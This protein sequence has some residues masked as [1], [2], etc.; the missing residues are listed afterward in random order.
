VLKRGNGR[1]TNSTEAVL[2]FAKSDSYYFDA[3]AVKEGFADKRAGNPGRY[4]WSHADAGL[5][6]GGPHSLHKGDGIVD[7]WNTD[8]NA[9]GRC[10]RSAWWLPLETTGSTESWF[11][12]PG[13]QEREIRGK[14][15]ACVDDKTE[16]MTK[17]GW[18]CHSELEDGD[19]IL[20][21]NKDLARLVWQPATFHRYEVKE[22]PMVSI[23]KRDLSM[24][25]TPNHRCLV[26]TQK[27]NLRVTEASALA[28]SNSIPV[29]A[30]MT[31]DTDEGCGGDF[32]ELLGWFLAEGHIKRNGCVGIS[33]SV[34]VNPEKVARIE[35]LLNRCGM[36]YVKRISKR[37]WR[38]RDASMAEFALSTGAS[39]GLLEAAPGKEMNE[40]LAMLPPHNAARL[41]AGLI[42]GDGHVR[43]D[44]RAC[45]VQK[46]KKTIDFVHLLA[47]RL[48]YRGQVGKRSDGTYT[49]FLT[50][51]RWLTLRSTDGKPM[52]PKTVN[53]S[54]VVWC[55]SVPSTFWLARRNGKQFITG[56]TFPAKLPELC[57]KMSTSE[58]GVCG[59]CGTPFAR[60]LDKSK[61]SAPTA[62]MKVAGCDSQGQYHGENQGDYREGEAQP[63]SDSKRSILESMAT[64]SRTIGWRAT[65][66]CEAGEPVPATV[67][68]CFAGLSTSGVAAL[69]LG[70]SYVGI[71]LNPKY[72]EMSRK[73]LA[74]AARQGRLAL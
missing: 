28:S 37:T 39:D 24:L 74:D 59:K 52:R 21:Y 61:V 13:G 68:D 65:C 29:S 36:V 71:E 47:V 15:F 56:N 53:Y 11:I 25:V 48:G 64:Q 73:R 10:L 5:R 41:L 38:G 33:Q 22:Q 63:P 26:L 43:D 7:G 35:S 19:E 1:P 50:H 20:A 17:R 3:E 9:T 4:H 27:G 6:G 32:E 66:G 62:A 18:C 57:I 46:H 70:R 2:M 44:G 34:A 16:A 31:T 42:G 14:H 67:L 23:E 12:N 58:R 40:R 54:G 55:P 30:D 60:V 51:N 49:L 8:G 45:F 72:A 69:R